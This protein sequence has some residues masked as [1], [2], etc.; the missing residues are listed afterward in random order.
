[1]FLQQLPER[2][3]ESGNIEDP[4][5]I[6]LSRVAAGG[7]KRTTKSPPQEVDFDSIAGQKVLNTGLQDIINQPVGKIREET[8]QP[9]ELPGRASRRKSRSWV[10]QDGQDG[11]LL[12]LLAELLRHFIGNGA[13]EGVAPHE[14]RAPR[15]NR[16]HRAKVVGGHGL[17]LFRSWW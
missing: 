2:L 12:S 15:L 14:I 6:Q 16:S 1:M 11:H 3:A 8:N 17:D 9:R 4:V 5:N 7:T 13:A 10:V